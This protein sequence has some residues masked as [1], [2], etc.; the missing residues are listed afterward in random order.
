MSEI[1][2]NWATTSAKKPQNVIDG[3]IDYLTHNSTVSTGRSSKQLGDSRLLVETRMKVA[4]FFNVQ[5]SEQVI[6]TKNATESMNM[7]LNGFLKKGDKVLTSKMEHNAVIRPLHLLEKKVIINVAYLPCDDEGVLLTENLEK[8]VSSETKAVVLSH[9]SNITG[10][11]QP[12]KKIFKLAKEKGI[13]TILDASQSAGVLPID[14]EDMC[15][16]ILVF[17]GHKSLLGLAGCG[18]FCLKEEVVSMIDPWIVGGTG[19]H[20]ELEE[21]PMFLPDKYEAG[22]MNIPGILSLNFGI[23]A[24]EEIGLENIRT[25][26]QKLL[27]QFMTGL[28]QLPVTILGPKQ[29]EQKVG[30]VSIIAKGFDTGELAADLYE[31][32]GIITRSG[33]HC[34]PKGHQV[35]GTF[36][37]GALRFSFGYA[38]TEE[39]INLAL[40]ALRELLI[41][42]S[43]E[44]VQNNSNN[45]WSLVI[46]REEI[47]N[48]NP[49]LNELLMKSYLN[50]L[51]TMDNPPDKILFFNTG[52]HLTCE[53]SSCLYDLQEIMLRGTQL[54]TCEQCL[55]FYQKTDKLMLGERTTMKV[56]AEAIS[57]PKKNVML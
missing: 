56:I 57:C 52:I 43:S 2:L 13:I 6:F 28:K 47:G 42:K 23:S 14:M 44:A 16:D 19:N 30:I 32:Y 41:G 25:H 54:L 39:E 31:E 10:A 7:V 46:S 36:P 18:G 1:N 15:V 51:I 3:M 12:I 24:I 35:L 22:T 50:S 29:T 37:E 8:I 21:Q 9:A 33:L 26:E 49:K 5:K 20:S 55:N 40:L 45:A 4:K 27:N 53:G 17:T 34:A 38:T 11:I 48:G